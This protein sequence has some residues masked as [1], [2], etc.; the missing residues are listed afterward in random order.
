MY[1]YEFFK[2]LNLPQIVILRTLEASTN[3]FCDIDEDWG[4][5]MSTVANSF[6]VVRWESEL[7]DFPELDKNER[8]FGSALK[9]THHKVRKFKFLERM[10]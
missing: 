6:S 8:P 4:R 3:G 7:I 5:A 1:F 10:Q 9:L 2:T